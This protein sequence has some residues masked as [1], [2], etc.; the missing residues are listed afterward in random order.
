M[1]CLQNSSFFPDHIFSLSLAIHLISLTCMLDK[2]LGDKV[3]NEMPGTFQ[4]R[5]QTITI[6][7]IGN[8]LVFAA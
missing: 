2:V 4:E 3:Q 7:D 6:S 1:D 8:T 5:A